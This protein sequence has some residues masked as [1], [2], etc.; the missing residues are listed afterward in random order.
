MDGMGGVKSFEGKPFEDAVSSP[1]GTSQYGHHNFLGNKK[2]SYL[3][4]DTWKI[5]M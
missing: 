3:V 2:L 5:N 4:N 1:G